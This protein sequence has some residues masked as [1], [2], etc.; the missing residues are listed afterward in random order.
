MSIVKPVRPY[1]RLE[2]IAFFRGCTAQELR[3][4]DRLGTPV[5]VKP[6][7]VLCRQGEIGNQFFVIIRGAATVERNGVRVARLGAGDAF[8]E[9]A[10]LAGSGAQPRVATVVADETT[11]VLVFSR[12]EFGSLIHLVPT[13][14]GPMLKRVSN[15]AAS[16][17]AE[18]ST[19]PSS[20][21]VRVPAI[22][23]APR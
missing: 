18:S 15:L 3:R 23:G 11:S 1:K 8:G 13:I 7:R 19:R 5:E 22:S 4:I 16:L 20:D 21:A 10:L 6:Q 14:A 9:L 2:S 12:A 17:A